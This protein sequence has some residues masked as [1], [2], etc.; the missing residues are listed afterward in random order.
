MARSEG[1]RSSPAAPSMRYLATVADQSNEPQHNLHNE[2]LV[3]AAQRIARY[4]DASGGGSTHNRTWI[5]RSRE[6]P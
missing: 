6:A 3:E 5:S 1:A 2:H 4:I